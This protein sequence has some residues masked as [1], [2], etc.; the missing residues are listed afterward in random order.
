MKHTHPLRPLTLLLL[1][2]SALVSC[3][4]AILS[5]P[6]DTIKVAF[7]K[8]PVLSGISAQGVTLGINLTLSSQV[9]LEYGTATGTY[10]KASPLTSAT[11][12]EHSITLGDLSPSTTYY[13]R[14]TA[15]LESGRQYKLDEKTFATTA[16]T[17]L[18]LVGTPVFTP[19]STGMVIAWTTNQACFGQAEYGTTTGTYTS[20]SVAETS[21]TTTH[22]ATITGLAAGT[23]YYVRLRNTLGTSS[24]VTTETTQA[25]PAATALALLA[26][27]VFSAVTASGMT[28]SW[29]TNQSCASLVEYGTTS[30]TYTGST[31]LEGTA[32]T[33][34]SAALSGLTA[35]TKYYVRIR[36]NGASGVLLTS[37]YSQNTVAAVP[38]A[39]STTPVFTATNTTMGVTWSTNLACVGLVEYGT[40]TGVYTQAS[41]VETTAATGHSA[42]LSGLTPGTTYYFRTRNTLGTE[43]LLTPEATQATTSA[44]ALTVSSTPLFTPSATGMTISWDTSLACTS[45]VE[46]GTATGV[47]TNSTVVE[48]SATLNHSASINGLNSGVTYYFRL[49]H[50]N[51]GS[52]LTSAEY[53]QATTS[54]LPTVETGPSVVATTTSL[55]ITWTSSLPATS[56]VEYGTVSGTYP[57]STTLTTTAGTS[58]SHTLTGLTLGTTYYYRLKMTNAIGTNTS[59]G[60]QST[61]PNATVKNRGIWLIGG[62]D[63]TTI[64]SAVAP[65]DLYDPVT[66]TWYPSITTLPTPVSFA[67]YAALNGFLYVIGGFEGSAG[68]ALNTVQ[69]Y[70]IASNTWTTGTPLPAA[71]ANIHAVVGG[72]RIFI[73]GGTTGATAGTAWAGAATSYEYTP[74]NSGTAGTWASKT[75]FG[76]ATSERFGYYDAGTVYNLG[77]RTAAATLSATTASHDGLVVDGG[78]AA[79]TGTGVT[80][81]GQE[82]VLTTILPRTGVSGAVYLPGGTA[83]G[84][85][86]LLG[87]IT[88]VGGTPTG[89]IGAGASPTG[90]GT[91]TVYYLLQPF[92]ANTAIWQAPTGTG[93]TLPTNVA[94]A[95]A[96]ISTAMSPARIYNFGG[97]ASITTAP[98][99][100][101]SYYT[102]LPTTFFGNPVWINSNT[103]AS[104]ATMPNARWG[105]GAVTLNQ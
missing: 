6:A 41:V 34:H 46:Y 49:R 105:H 87:G 26:A 31:V 19:T 29:I 25:T 24:L 61:D 15:V 42:T 77:G 36:N 33:T 54:V 88:T 103:W 104:T 68:T 23:T 47:Y 92:S 89:F 70:N 37:E 55:T 76:A 56:Q 99:A 18:A 58:H 96:A 69:I 91:N 65:V 81:L 80:T 8:D 64:G 102:N 63:G 16:A 93:A 86:I 20:S 94:F 62:L 74:N 9:I 66:N 83:T 78:A 44:T 43:V 45:L 40:A 60:S 73:L 28:V 71:R 1:V 100:T 50:F 12:L 75:A 14:V 48:A 97:T 57:S 59:T 85:V 98:A 90:P 52:G 79:G 53:T 51:A 35:G 2:A 5:E 95:A 30:G 67:G 38:L 7:A 39:L 10:T 84:C 3:Q 101:T 72:G 27:P 21:L 13:Y 32:G 22:T 82:T 4:S 17:A 11:A